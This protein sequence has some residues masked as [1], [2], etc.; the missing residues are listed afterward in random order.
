MTPVRSK[1]LAFLF[2]T[3]NAPLQAGPEFTKSFFF[4]L[5]AEADSVQNK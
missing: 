5:F 2:F 4:F 3:V 1:R